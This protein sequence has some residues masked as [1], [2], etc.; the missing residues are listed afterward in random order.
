MGSNDCINV[1]SLAKT[2]TLVPVT[3]PNCISIIYHVVEE[4]VN[5][6]EISSL[7]RRC[8][9]VRVHFKQQRLLK[10]RMYFFWAKFAC[11]YR[12][13]GQSSAVQLQLLQDMSTNV[14]SLISSG[15]SHRVTVQFNHL[16]HLCVLQLCIVIN[17]LWP[18]LPY[19]HASHI[20]TGYKLSVLVVVNWHHVEGIPCD[21][22]AG[23]CNWCNEAGID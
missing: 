4:M 16:R 15:A 9:C 6:R 18:R 1:C 23:A 3:V 19:D 14:L 11:L 10:L 20:Y 8:V 17:R 21:G 22:R 13:F 2:I 12:G 7:K 5:C